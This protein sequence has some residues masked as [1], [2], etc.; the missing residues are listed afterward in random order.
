MIFG[1]KEARRRPNRWDSIT[2]AP[3]AIARNHCGSITSLLE[4]FQYDQQTALLAGHR[5]GIIGAW[6]L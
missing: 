5:C 1:E 2:S 4:M 3:P 6:F